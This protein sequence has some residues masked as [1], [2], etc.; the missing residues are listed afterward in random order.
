MPPAS[1][2]AAPADWHQSDEDWA[3]VEVRGGAGGSEVRQGARWKGNGKKSTRL[4]S[5]ALSSSVISPEECNELKDRG[6]GNA[7][8]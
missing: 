3:L 4:S 8:S 6:P 7:R 1:L 5:G 2:H